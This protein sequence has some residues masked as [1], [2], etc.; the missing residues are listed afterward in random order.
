MALVTVPA[1]VQFA[2]TRQGLVPVRVTHPRLGLEWAVAEVLD[3]RLRLTG[4]G[5]EVEVWQYLLL[6]GGPLPGDPS[7][8]GGSR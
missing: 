6:V 7:R 2:T 8:S 4:R 3:E 5:Q 1:Q